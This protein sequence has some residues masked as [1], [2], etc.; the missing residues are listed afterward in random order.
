[1]LGLLGIGELAA[2]DREDYVRI[3]TRLAGD[4]GWRDEIAGR[5]RGRSS[6]LFDRPE[7]IEALAA[8]LESAS[9]AGRA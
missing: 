9:P 1:M 3:A 7:P 6:V 5:I 4:R 8:F 2:R